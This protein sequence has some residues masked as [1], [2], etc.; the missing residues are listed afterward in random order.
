MSSPAERPAAV[1]PQRPLIRPATVADAPALSALARD[2]FVASFGT[3]Y[4]P[5]D[6]AA[7]LQDTY[8]PTRQAEEIADPA[9]R[10]QVVEVDGQLIGFIKIG[11]VKL[12]LPEVE[13]GAWEVHRL[14]FHK[15]AQGQGLGAELLAW[16]IDVATA[17]GSPALYLGV[18]SENHGARRFY[19]RHRFVPIGGYWFK[20]GRARDEEVILR[21]KLP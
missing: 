5:T 15:A 17:A 10:H 12:P 2:T 16:A 4:D 18:W 14:Y 1:T 9:T 7:F 19:S 21:R 20:V 8:T 6:L 11:E 13:A 3:L